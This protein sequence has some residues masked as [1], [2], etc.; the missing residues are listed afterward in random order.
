MDSSSLYAEEILTTVLVGKDINQEREVGLVPTNVCIIATLG[1]I[2][3]LKNKYS[4]FLSPVQLE[5]I[6]GYDAVI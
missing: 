2:A 3:C 5:I 6:C 1:Y 4:C